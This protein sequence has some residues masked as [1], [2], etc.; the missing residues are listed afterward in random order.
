MSRNKP[1]HNFEPKLSVIDLPT[2]AT[3][4]GVDPGASGGIAMFRDGVMVTHKMPA[5]ERDTWEIL[6]GCEPGVCFIEKVGA[7]PQMGVTSAFKFGR[8][9]GLLHGLLIASGLRIEYVSPQRWQ[10]VLRLPKVGGKIGQNGT[11]KKNRNKAKAQELYPELRITHATADAILLCEYGLR[12]VGA[13]Q[14]ARR[15]AEGGQW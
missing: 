8:S 2:D 3:I 12:M 13:S 15:R 14:E 4:V 10:L 7:T 9:A 1:Y 6:A 5:T 11:A